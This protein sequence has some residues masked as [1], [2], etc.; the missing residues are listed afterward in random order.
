M[1]LQMK[2]DGNA[3]E[4]HNEVQELTGQKDDLVKKN[5]VLHREKKGNILALCMHHV[6]I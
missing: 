6:L 3:T 1:K 2:L 5:K 4:Y